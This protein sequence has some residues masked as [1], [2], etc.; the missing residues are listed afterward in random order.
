MG[1]YQIAIDI[2]PSE[3]DIDA[4]VSHLI[5]YNELQ[6]ER[7]RWQRLAI[8]V[9]DDEGAIVGGLNGFTRWDWLFISHLWVDAPL[10]GRGYG[11]ALVETA[12]QE[13][14]KRGCLHA[15]ADTFDF[16]ARGFYEK[17]GYTIFGV[18]EDFPKGHTRYFMHRRDLNRFPRNHHYHN[19]TLEQNGFRISHRRNGTEST[20]STVQ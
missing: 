4:I 8:V 3:E 7:E 16:Q 13:A 18:L 11:R 5:H 12:E 15:H 10:R 19:T 14:L 20:T 9:R 6:A 17:M 2:N 1:A